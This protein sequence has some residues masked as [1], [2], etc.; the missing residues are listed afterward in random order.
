MRAPLS[1]TSEPTTVTA[2]ATLL[3]MPC[4]VCR[5]SRRS[6]TD[7]FGKRVTSPACMRARASGSAGPLSEAMKVCGAPSKT[8]GL[9]TNMKPP[10]RKSCQFTALMLDTRAVITRPRMSKL[11]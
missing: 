11:I 8:P 1:S 7:T 3:T 5:I 4:T 2:S 6:I 10:A 9:K